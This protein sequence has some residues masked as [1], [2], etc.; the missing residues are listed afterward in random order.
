[1]SVG[2]G[3]LGTGSIGA[4]HARRLALRVSGAHVAAVFDLDPNRLAAVRDE[5]GVAGHA[6]AEDLIEDPAVEAV[7]IASPGT[8]HA[9]LVLACIEMGTPVL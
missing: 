2:V 8:T 4:D 7:V 9:D 3:V 6:R 1:M 5:L